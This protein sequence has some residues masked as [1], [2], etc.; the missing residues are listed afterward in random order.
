MQNNA[1]SIQSLKTTFFIDLLNNF[2]C[3]NSIVA[4]YVFCLQMWR[5]TLIKSEVKLLL[6]RY[7][8]WDI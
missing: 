6:Q 7:T 5:I 2:Y 4:N 3:N 1:F 8:Y